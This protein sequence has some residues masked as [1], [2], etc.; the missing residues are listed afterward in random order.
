MDDE[1]SLT[2][3]PSPMKTT[4]NN[5]PRRSPAAKPS[6]SPIIKGP[7]GYPIK[8]VDDGEESLA[9]STSLGSTPNARSVRSACSPNK[10]GSASAAASQLSQQP[11][12]PYKVPQAVSSAL[13]QQS[14]P[15][16][17]S[18]AVEVEGSTL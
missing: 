17:P 14:M 2:G 13:S 9:L 15:Y 11:P 10:K 3:L 1:P 16:R 6:Q 18:S 7:G 8:E 12:S 4:S 5:S